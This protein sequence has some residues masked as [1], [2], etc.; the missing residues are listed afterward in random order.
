MK[1]TILL[2]EEDDEVAA[3]LTQDLEMAGFQVLYAR[4]REEAQSAVVR[5][6]TLDCVVH[7]LHAHPL[8][9]SEGTLDLGLA[10]IR[11]LRAQSAALPIVAVLS[12]LTWEHDADR[13]ARSAGADAVIVPQEIESLPEAIETAL[14]RRR[15]SRRKTCATL[16]RQPEPSVEAA[17]KTV[18]KPRRKRSARGGEAAPRSVAPTR[19]EDHGAFSFVSERSLRLVHVIAERYGLDGEPPRSVEYLARR[20]GLSTLA[21]REIEE[22]FLALARR[23]VSERK[24]S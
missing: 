22:R 14:A 10:S 16:D 24:G 1:K 12:T 23:I 18:K 13:L 17:P 4:S 8:D 15:G 3:P 6:L 2:V 9:A 11:G 5:T 19:P 7:V 21:V 20:H